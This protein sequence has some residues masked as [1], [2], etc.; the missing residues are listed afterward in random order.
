VTGRGARAQA[1]PISSCCCSRRAG[2]S[3][4]QASRPVGIFANLSMFDNYW[5]FG[6]HDIFIY[7]TETETTVAITEGT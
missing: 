2:T 3:L 1:Q 7:L 4:G 6:R 5:N